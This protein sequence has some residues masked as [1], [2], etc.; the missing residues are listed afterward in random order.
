MRECHKQMDTPIPPRVLFTLEEMR[1]KVFNSPQFMWSAAQDRFFLST[2]RQ[3][4][5]QEWTGSE[6]G[7]FD[8]LIPQYDPSDEQDT[9]DTDSASE[10]R[11]EAL[12]WQAKN[13][14]GDRGDDD[15]DA[16]VSR[17]SSR[18]SGR[19]TA[20][21]EL[22]QVPD[23]PHSD[24][25]FMASEFSRVKKE[26]LDL[27]DVVLHSFRP[28]SRNQSMFSHGRH[29]FDFFSSR[30]LLILF[31]VWGMFI[32]FMLGCIAYAF[33]RLFQLEPGQVIAPHDFLSPKNE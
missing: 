18:S 9:S 10:I 16:S 19:T 32:T 6:T 17:V 29:E 25:F 5:E 11:D 23:K 31:C 21:L 20:K 27:P 14:D 15:D 22:E 7:S 13:S 1:E 2:D 30:C 4:R 28:A 3:K 33:V 12:Y 8:S 24:S 26:P